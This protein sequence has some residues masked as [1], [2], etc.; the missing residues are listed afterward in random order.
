MTCTQKTESITD[1]FT[2]KYGATSGTSSSVNLGEPS[3]QLVC[4]TED[5]NKDSGSVA[6]HRNPMIKFSLRKEQ[7]KAEILWALKHVMSHFS[8]NSSTDIT[9]IFNACFKI[10]LLH[11]KWSLGPTSDL[12]WSVLALH[13]TSS[14]SYLWNWQ[15]HNVLSSHLMSHV[16]MNFTKNRCTSLWGTLI[17]T[18]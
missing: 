10:V 14:N 16:T 17:K 3:T 4:D 5:T 11:R 1:F 18:E 13:H 8:F 9:H 12:I 15:K 2:V 7:H 6:T